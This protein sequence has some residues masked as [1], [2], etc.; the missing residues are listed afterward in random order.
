MNAE[1][2]QNLRYKLQKRV[3]RLN[4][5]EYQVFH[6]LLKQFWGFLKSY[7]IFVG[8]LED[9]EH[10]CP[11]AEDKAKEIV[12]NRKVIIAENELE[13]AAISYFVIKKCVESNDDTMEF[14]LG[15]IYDSHSSHSNDM[16][17]YFKSLFLEPLYE[18]LDEQIDDQMVI[19]ALLKRYK[20]KCEW[21][22]RDYLFNLWEG[23]TEK[24]EKLL[25]S[26]LYEY[27]HDQGLD[28]IIE[29]SSA[30]GEID[31]IA[32]QK[33][34]DPLLADAKIFNPDKSKGK[35]YIANGFKQVYT[36]TQDYNEPFGYLVIYKTSGR[37]LK[38]NLSKQMQSTPFLLHNNKTI[39]LITIDIFPHKTSASKRGILEPVE[40]TEKDLIRINEDEKE[41]SK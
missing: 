15:G 40:I 10:R 2:I 30:S 29:P 32:D 35:S 6:Y 17:S 5:S 34:D 18:Y 22:Q 4:S 24:G 37:D 41:D 13:D 16:L 20:H 7:P 14:M 8:I 23:N 25:A 33:S 36:Y 1:H 28:F 11:S 12:E 26:H 39:F 27:L 3:R 21:F 19:L 31:L 9:L 38:F